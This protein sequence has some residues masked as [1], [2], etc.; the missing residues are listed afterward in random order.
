MIPL[1]SEPIRAGFSYTLSKVVMNCIHTFPWLA[2]KAKS[3]KKESEEKGKTKTESESESADK[4]K[5]P[6]KKTGSFF[7]KVSK[8]E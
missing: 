3:E 2:P 7:T 4:E 5:P 6:V 8:N 1:E